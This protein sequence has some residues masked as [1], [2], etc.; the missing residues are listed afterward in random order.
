M[1]T[2][3]R[4]VT[5][6]EMLI[7][8]SLLSILTVGLALVLRVGLSALDKVNAKLMANRRAASVQRILRSEIE[9]FIPATG[10]C[11]GAPGIPPSKIA[12]FDGR[13]DSMRLVSSYSLQEAARGAP[14]ILEFHVIPGEQDKGV[15]LI[16]NETIYAG[17]LSTLGMCL[18]VLPDPETG[19]TRPRFAPIEAGSRSF[20]LAD[21]LAYCRFSYRRA[22]PPPALEQW[23]PAWIFPDWPTAV[24]VDMAPLEPDST[25]VPL[26]TATVPIRVNRQPMVSY[27]D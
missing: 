21:R 13:P 2:G 26:V 25:R 5:L 19:R 9:S 27:A 24:R 18:G 8:V 4:G 16:V 10:V 14:R 12:F 11:P 3:S 6:I 15:R 17:P 20:V 1:R 22:L 7:A 23:L